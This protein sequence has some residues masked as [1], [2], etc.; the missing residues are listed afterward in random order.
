LAV[1]PGI[2]SNS[3]VFIPPSDEDPRAYGPWIQHTAQIDAGNSGGPLLVPQNDPLAA[4]AVI[5]V[6]TASGTNRQ[7]ANYAIPVSRIEAFIDASLNKT[8]AGKAL[9]KL[10]ERAAGFVQG[11]SVNR[12]VYSQIARYLSNECTASN[13]AAAIF[14]VERRANRSV[15]NDI[16]NR[17]LFTAIDYAVGWLIESELRELNTEGVLRPS[18]GTITDNADGTW[19]APLD[20]AIVSR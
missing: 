8:E 3:R 15:Q 13:A 19:T 18:L 6:N 1:W 12:A 7:A 10:E 16:F 20:F 2:V 5:G 14:E 11:L 9:E 17:Y 4:Y